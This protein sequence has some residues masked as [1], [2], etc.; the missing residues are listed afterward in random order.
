MTRV[1]YT[2]NE[3]HFSSQ[4]LNET[5]T[6]MVRHLYNRNGVWASDKCQM[7]FSDLSFRHEK[8]TLICS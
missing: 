7:N 1:T 2:A 4:A 3:S 6:G 5:E 8:G